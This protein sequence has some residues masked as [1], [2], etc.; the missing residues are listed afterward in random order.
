MFKSFKWKTGALII[1]DSAFINLAYI[2]AYIFRFENNI[3]EVF[4]RTYRHE[5]ILITLIYLL[6]FI[7]FKLYKS[8]WTYAGIDEFL[9]GVEACAAAGAINFIYSYFNR[10]IPLGIGIVAAMFALIFV[11]GFRISFRVIRRLKNR[12]SKSRCKDLKRVMVIGAGSAG[13]IIINEMKNSKETNLYPVCIIDDD[14]RKIGTR[15]SGVPVVGDRFAIDNIVKEKNVDLILIAIPS[16]DGNNKRELINI[17]KSSGCKVKTI[18]GLYELLNEDVFINKI[19]DVSPEELLGKAPVKVDEK[20]IRGYIEGKKVL[21]TG[22]GGAVGSELCREIT[23]YGPRKLIVFDINENSVFDLQNELKGNYSDLDLCIATGSVT[24]RRRLEQLFQDYKPEIIFHAAAYKHASFIEDSPAEA[25]K[26]N[27]YGTLNAAEMADHYGAEKFIFISD[28]K[29]VNPGNIIGAAVRICEM[30][31]QSI[32][33]KSNTNFSAVRFGNVFE[34]KGSIGSLFKKQIE[35]GGPILVSHKDSTRFFMTINEASKLIIQAGAMAT[36]GEI[37]SLD[38]GKPVRIYDLARDLIK[39]SGLEPDRDIEIKITGLEPGEK[40][41]EKVAADEEGLNKTEHEKI[42][43]SRSVFDNFNFL[44]EQL[45][46]LRF[47]LEKGNKKVIIDNVLQTVKGLVPNFHNPVFQETAASRALY[48]SLNLKSSS[49]AKEYIL[50][51][52]IWMV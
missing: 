29:A 8:L 19:R 48:D 18:P 6:C 1:I 3:L 28:D 40:L 10:G 17:C 27:V 5:A 41:H 52:L 45:E 42:F 15:V 47:V 30:I 37:F 43:I 13:N 21:I 25:I 4:M 36:G 2:L 31:V 12:I 51:L 33:K 39:L 32:D 7:V 24:D 22:G 49:R 35:Q 20:K 26:N 50:H 44:K 11:V 46:N 9:L 38:M 16:L 14:K 34:S 23:K